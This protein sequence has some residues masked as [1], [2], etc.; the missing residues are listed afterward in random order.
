MLNNNN[1]QMS[2]MDALAIVSFFIGLANY[3][4]NVDQNSM[5]EAISKAV[6]DVHSHLKSQDE[7]IDKIL[8]LIDKEVT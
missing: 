5:Q 4:E 3:G 7:K 2:L 6:E 8:S 1:S